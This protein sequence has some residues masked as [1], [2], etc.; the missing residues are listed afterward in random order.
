VKEAEVIEA[1]KKALDV[2]RFDIESNVTNTQEWDS[3]G[4]LT[5]FATLSRMTKGKSDEIGGIASMTSVQE[6][7]NALKENKIIE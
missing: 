5:I 4:S 1:L 6:I 7:I 2:K 3:L